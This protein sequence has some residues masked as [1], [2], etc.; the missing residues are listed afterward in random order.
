MAGNLFG[1]QYV[2]S[3][4]CPSEVPIASDSFV[5]SIGINI[6]ATNEGTSPYTNVSLVTADI[7]D[8][9]IRHIRVM[10]LAIG[11]E[12]K[13]FVSIATGAN[14]KLM[15]N[16]G[17]S[18]SGKWLI[19]TVNNVIAPS[20]TLKTRKD[21]IT[22]YLSSIELF[23]GPNEPECHSSTYNC[24][25]GTVVSY[26][27]GTIQY[28]NALANTL[29]RPSDSYDSSPP[30][31]LP[32]AGP[33]GCCDTGTAAALKGA[34]FDYENIHTYVDNGLSPDWGITGGAK[35]PGSCDFVGNAD[36]GVTA[37]LPVIVS[38]TGYSTGIT[39]DVGI[40]LPVSQ[41][42]QAKYQSRIFADA[43]L[44]SRIKRTYTWELF[45]DTAAGNANASWGLVAVDSTGNATIKKPSYNAEKSLIALLA[46]PGVSF[47]P[48]ALDFIITAP[49]QVEHLLLQKSNGD[50]YLLL[51]QEV[52]V[53]G[54]SNGTGSDVINP[55]VLVSVSFKKT[56]SSATQYSYDSSWSLV[57]GQLSVSNQ[58]VV[59]VP[60]FVTVIK[61]QGE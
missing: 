6:G 52:P 49:A 30:I 36:Q 8:L 45:D 24:V 25:N 31:T 57:A 32:L 19:D 9:G 61:I 2:V 50:Y 12:M 27:S 58:L 13:N 60:D 22:P 1:F 56:F 41:L 47:S 46:E 16:L 10:P 54:Y 23:E 51:W 14:A 42:A 40:V 44:N 59:S 11:S 37:Q 15:F 38:E 18:G 20:N 17:R 3:S 34:T 4:P 29:R 26:P 48:K 5:D 33:A 55:S 35:Y 21:Y 7:L 43:F 53:Y 39:K 28:Q